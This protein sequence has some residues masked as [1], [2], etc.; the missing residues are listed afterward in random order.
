MTGSGRKELLDDGV[1][2][3]LAGPTKGQIAN[4]ITLKVVDKSENIYY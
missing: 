3:Y 2:F 1:E 4:I